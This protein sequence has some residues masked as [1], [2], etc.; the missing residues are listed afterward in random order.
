M[1]PGICT[2]DL[3]EFCFTWGL[4]P[5]QAEGWSRVCSNQQGTELPRKGPP[6]TRDPWGGQ[7]ARWVSLSWPAGCSNEMHAC[8]VCGSVCLSAYPGAPALFP[9]SPGRSGLLIRTR[10]AEL[11]LCTRPAP[12]ARLA[13]RRQGWGGQQ[14]APL[15]LSPGGPN[16]QA[17]DEARGST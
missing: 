4:A 5:K 16:H 7:S 12:G 1:S 17:G 6:G 3:Q 10:T 8:S 9:Q 2:S 14:T 13:A 15:V 11:Q